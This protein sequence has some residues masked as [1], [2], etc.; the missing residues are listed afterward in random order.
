LRI[1]IPEQGIPVTKNIKYFMWGFQHVFRGSLEQSVKSVMEA[2][3]LAMDPEPHA[4]LIGFLGEDEADEELPRWPICVEPEDGP[5]H[6]DHLVNVVSDG[7]YLLAH[8]PDRNFHISAPHLDKAFRDRLRDR[9]R[10]QALEERLHEL[11][12]DQRV[13]VGPSAR[14]MAYEVHTILLFPL[15]FFDTVP[16]ITPIPARPGHAALP[17]SLSSA[18]I[19]EVLRRSSRSLLL[20]DPGSG[21][22]VLE[23][24]VAEVV[25]AAAEWFLFAMG[26]HADQSMTSGLFEALNAVSLQRL[27]GEVGSGGLAL[28][29]SEM[30]NVSVE[31]G[32]ERPVRLSDKRALRKLLQVAGASGMRLL[33][34]GRTV[35]ALGRVDESYDPRA[36]TL[37]MISI[38]GEGTWDV[39]SAGPLMEVSFGSPHL[40]TRKLEQGDF[41]DTTQRVFQDYPDV[42]TEF[43]WQLV[44]ESI[45]A[46]HGTLLV[47]SADAAG[48]ARR[49]GDQA[50]PVKPHK[51]SSSVLAGWTSIDGAVMLAPDGMCH[52]A[53]VILDGR[54]S[55]EGDPSRGARYNSAVRY[56]AASEVPALAIVVSEDG[57]VDLIPHLRPRISRHRTEEAVRTAENIAQTTPVNFEAFYRKWRDLV[58]LEFYLDEDQCKRANNARAAVEDVRM[59][60]NMMTVHDRELKPDP[61]KSDEYFID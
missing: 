5:I 16:S 61:K 37:F 38:R 32:L 59:K 47:I 60:E 17:T 56:V 26:E 22:N 50:L 49:L 8:H 18:L 20:P 35:P 43:L 4:V 46:A 33:T 12:P 31:I 3:G 19:E 10:A 13:F 34:D 51:P 44:N 52:A 45:D 29:D 57:M 7:R 30:N 48:E 11:L 1:L 2:I 23:A 27:E 14:V 9:C 54:A 15:T 25:R 58:Q 28:V 21:L 42:Q 55:P 40:P 41:I 24:S 36:D 6:P 53:G 39:S